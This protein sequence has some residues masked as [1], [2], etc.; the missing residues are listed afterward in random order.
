MQNK[1]NSEKV[2]QTVERNTNIF[3]ATLN[4]VKLSI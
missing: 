2:M 1:I 4:D 3:V